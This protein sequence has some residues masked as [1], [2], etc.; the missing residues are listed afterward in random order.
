M[1]DEQK[2][3]L[4]T[5]GLS[6]LLAYR[7]AGKRGYASYLKRSRGKYVQILLLYSLAGAACF[8]AGYPLMGAFVAGALWGV[9]Y[10]DF[11]W[12]RSQNVFWPLMEKVMDWEKVEVL[13]RELSGGEAASSPT[14]AAY[15]A[16]R[17]TREQTAIRVTAAMSGSVP[18]SITTGQATTEPNSNAD[19]K[20][21]VSRRHRK[22][23]AA[24]APR[25]ASPFRLGSSLPAPTAA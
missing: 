20:A 9:L 25:H 4:Q 1:T 16:W 17:Q 8:F 12:I 11:Q 5:R 7:E 22:A 2:R 19:R 21:T 14:Y 3:V 23:P 6:N 24:L 10:R 15:R 13:R 18:G